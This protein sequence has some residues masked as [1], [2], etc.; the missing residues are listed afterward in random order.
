MVYL[1][2]PQA[3]A[4]HQISL[5]ELLF[6]NENTRKPYVN[7]NVANTKTYELEEAS[8][9]ALSHVDIDN[10]ILILCQFNAATA[11]FRE[12]DRSTLYRFYKI[13]KRS[14]GLR[15]ISEPEP[16]LMEALRTLKTILEVNFGALYHTSA[17]AY[18]KKRSIVSALQRHQ[19]NT[20]H[21]FAKFDIHDFFGS[22]TLEF[23]MS[24][25]SM[26]FPFSEVCKNPVGYA[27]LRDAIELGFLN[28]GLPQGTPLSPTLTNIMMIPVDFCIN[29]ALRAYE[30]VDFVYTRYADDFLVSSYT[31]FALKDVQ[32]IIVDVLKQFNAPF[33]LNTDKTRFGSNTG[34]GANWNLGLMLNAQNEITIGR[35][36][37]KNFKSSLTAYSRD[38]I[39]GRTWNLE[40]IQHVLGE[41]SFFRMV[42]KQNAESVVANIGERFGFD[43]IKS[44]RADLKFY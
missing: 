3:P 37:K 39:D 10:L 6:P 34:S 26:I 41:Y 8:D 43:P 12:V 22:T 25:L 1:T 31:K 23:V 9:K 32:R 28:G 38:K 27:A 4:Y 17:F 33:A 21:W 29:K 7:Y 14:G 19:Q 5:E 20:S 42:E 15:T 40:D 44:M 13:P 16:Q 24:Q 11:H 36:R 18:V 2:V 30:G 35:S